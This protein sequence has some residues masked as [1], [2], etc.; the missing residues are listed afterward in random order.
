[1]MPELVGKQLEL[2]KE[3]VPKIS[4][5]ALLGNPANAGTAPQLRRAQDAARTL[6]LRLQAVEA[7]DPSEIDGAFVA[8]ARERAG[9]VIVLIDRVFLDQRTRI[10]NLA[11]K[12]RLPAVYGMEDHVEAGGLIIY[13]PSV[14]ELVINLKTAK[15]LGL[16][17]PPSLLVRA[18]RVID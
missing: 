3:L 15:A 8:M 17:I 12:R 18:N 16:T 5:V 9:A 2:I 7:R 4:R 10:A 6:G 14:P 11:A 13:G 1:M